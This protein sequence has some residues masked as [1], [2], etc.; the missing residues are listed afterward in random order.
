VSEIRKVPALS[1][2]QQVGLIVLRTLI[3][4]HFVY[5]GY[6][7]VWR[8]AWT[9][10]GEVLGPWSSAGYLRVANGPFADVFHRLAASSWLP[11]IDK[12]VAIALIL[13]GLSLLLGLFTQAGCVG[14]FVLLAMFYLSFLP[15]SGLHET[16]SEGAYLIVNKN[17]VEAAA[18]LAV[19]AFRTGGIAGLDLLRRRPVA[20]PR[21]EEAA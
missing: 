2:L 9:R 1:T 14:A 20:P 16:G 7:K 15:T 21:V 4:W 10:T 17:L 13:V 6:F 12:A 11:T 3:G 19:Y 18:V 5:E 8:P